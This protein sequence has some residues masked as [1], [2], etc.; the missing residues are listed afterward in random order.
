MMIW[1]EIKLADPM[2]WLEWLGLVRERWV[3]SSWLTP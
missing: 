2:I 1:L 3:K